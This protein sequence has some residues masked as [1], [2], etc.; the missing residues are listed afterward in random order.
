MAEDRIDRAFEV[1][2]RPLEP[3]PTFR[4]QLFER[5]LRESK[6]RPS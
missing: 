6:R 5:L 3:D 1:L 2:D 4:R